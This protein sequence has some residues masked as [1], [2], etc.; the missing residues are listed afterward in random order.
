MKVTILTEPELRK[1][2]AMDEEAF[3]AV[4]DGFFR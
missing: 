1:C 3:K 4:A 2:V